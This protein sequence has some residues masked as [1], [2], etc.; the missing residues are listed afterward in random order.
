MLEPCF[1]AA[2][3]VYQE[4]EVLANIALP[5]VEKRSSLCMQRFSCS[6][7]HTKVRVS[8]PSVGQRGMS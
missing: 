2:A 8:T 4:M 7:F 5:T 3:V 1:A 6:P